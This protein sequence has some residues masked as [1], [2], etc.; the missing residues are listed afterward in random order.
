M[1][2]EQ[3]F[4]TFLLHFTPTSKRFSKAIL[5][6]FIPITK[7]NILGHFIPTSKWLSNAILCPFVPIWKSNI[8]SS[9]N[10]YMG[11][12]LNGAINQISIKCN[13]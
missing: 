1:Q 7:T 3:F 4:M 11:K 8:L 2:A 13:I 10:P 12:P 6:P 9:F 5:S